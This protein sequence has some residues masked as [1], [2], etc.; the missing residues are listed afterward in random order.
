MKQLS[1]ALLALL[2]AACGGPSEQTPQADA[3][4]PQNGGTLRV[5]LDGDPQ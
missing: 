5:A 4:K 2:L 1:V 3:S